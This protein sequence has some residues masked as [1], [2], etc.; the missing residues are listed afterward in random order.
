MFYKC[1]RLQHYAS[2]PLG[3]THTT[4]T[5]GHQLVH[6][7]SVSLRCFYD[8]TKGAEGAKHLLKAL[9]QSA[10]LEEHPLHPTAHFVQ[11]AVA[12][13]DAGP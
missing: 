11:N 1:E 10:A 12:C 3:H 8:N 9:A 7:T 6:C 2:E 4:S 13:A 5:N